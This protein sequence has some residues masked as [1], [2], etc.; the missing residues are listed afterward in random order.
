MGFVCNIP[1]S[2]GSSLDSSSRTI[3]TEQGTYVPS[4]SEEKKLLSYHQARHVSAIPSGETK[5]TKCFER[6]CILNFPA[7][8]YEHIGYSAL[9]SHQK[10]QGGT[11]LFAGGDAA[12]Q[13]A[14]ERSRTRS[15]PPFVRILSDEHR[16]VRAN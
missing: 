6:N 11:E 4:P 7:P 5:I 8:V 16:K 9:S 14:V 12:F 15:R 3:V 13:P 10:K 1:K 2:L